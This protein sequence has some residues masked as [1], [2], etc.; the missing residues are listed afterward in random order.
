MSSDSWE[1]IK[2]KAHRQWKW[3]SGSNNNPFFL[4]FIYL[5][6]NMDEM[7]PEA[8]TSTD[9]PRGRYNW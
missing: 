2:Q 6:T 1:T 4:L 5:F 7:P 8:V 9:M 3:P